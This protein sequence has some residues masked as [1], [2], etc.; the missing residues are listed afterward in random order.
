MTGSV[1]PVKRPPQSLTGST[2][3]QAAR[4]AILVTKIL[5]VSL[6]ETVCI[7]FVKLCPEF[8]AVYT[9]SLLSSTVRTVRRQKSSLSHQLAVLCCSHYLLQVLDRFNES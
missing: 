7:D 6:L 2:A 5:W 9:K 8:L 1:L 4:D 3:V